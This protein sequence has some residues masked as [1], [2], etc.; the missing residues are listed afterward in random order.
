M[1]P[2][3]RGISA[4]THIADIQQAI[5]ITQLQLG[6]KIIIVHHPRAQVITNEDDVCAF[7]QG[8]KRIILITSAAKCDHY[9]DPGKCDCKVY[10]FLEHVFLLYL[11][12]IYAITTY[13][14][15]RKRW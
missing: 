8:D 13:L 11:V 15:A 3:A 1:R 9:Y 2:E 14:K 5:R 10:S 6:L 12:I 4:I 7:L